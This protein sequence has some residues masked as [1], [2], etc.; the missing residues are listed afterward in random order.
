MFSLSLS[1]LVMISSEQF[2]CK[3][4]AA[5]LWIFQI[6]FPFFFY[7]VGRFNFYSDRMI[8]G[9][10]PSNLITGF[11]DAN[12]RLHFLSCSRRRVAEM[13]LQPFFGSLPVPLGD[14]VRTT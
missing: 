2:G 10:T 5:A 7:P 4:M 6:Y 13:R 1:L 12:G 9:Y 8:D 11:M 14:N 3:S